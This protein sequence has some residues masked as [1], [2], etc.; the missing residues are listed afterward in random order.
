MS[1]QLKSASDNSPYL[2]VVQLLVAVISQSPPFCWLSRD[3]AET[4][5][6]QYISN[7]NRHRW[8][9]HIQWCR[10]LQ[11]LGGA[12]LSNFVLQ[13]WESPFSKWNHVSESL[14]NFGPSMYIDLR[15]I[16]VWSHFFDLALLRSEHSPIQT[17]PCCLGGGWEICWAWRCGAPVQNR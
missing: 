16:H 6:I 3:V 2:Q 14:D 4:S 1:G 11:S 17:S 12:E 8:L 15:Q 10:M 7:E 9:K 5:I 13:I